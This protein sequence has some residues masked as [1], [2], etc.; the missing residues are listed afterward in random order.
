MKYSGAFIHTQKEKQ[1]GMEAK[2]HILAYRAGL[3]D[4]VSAGIYNFTP[5]GQSVI[6]NITNIIREEMNNIGGLE[7]SLPI[8]QPASLWEKSKRWEVYGDEMM[9]VQNR[10]GREFCLGPTHEEVVTDMVSRMIKSSKSLPVALY[11]FGKKFRDEL[12]PRYGLLRTREFLMKDAYTFDMTE[13][14]ANKHYEN[15]REAYHQVFRRIGVNAIP[16]A[17]DG[18]EVGGSFSEEF[19]APSEFGEDRIGKENGK[20]VKLEGAINEHDITNIQ[21][22]I[23]VGHIFKL[24]TKYSDSMGFQ[25]SNGKENISPIM[26][27]YG[28][29]VSRLVTAIIEQNHDNN[30]IIWP[31]E[32]APYDIHISP[33]QMQNEGVKDLA[34]KTYSILSK[35]YNVLL[36]DRKT[37][38]GMK[39]KD[40]EL[41]GM[42]TQIVIGAR[43]AENNKVEMYRR[44]NTGKKAIVSL[45]N[46]YKYISENRF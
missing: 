4:Q 27:C 33:L 39:M 35:E 22:G 43:N 26:G 18:G 42:P 10:E 15:M 24:G 37:G 7:V 36:D 23:E 3:I 25:L 6:N 14:E 32:V 29:G 5:L 17:A 45:D 46:V 19:I 38:A 9:K 16:I 34:D 21:K 28:L 44:N 2:G 8:V 13:D 30:G 20:Y 41:L 12:R 40:A 31:T 1:K 11:Q